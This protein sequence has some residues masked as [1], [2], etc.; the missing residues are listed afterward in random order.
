MAE[1]P[2]AAAYTAP[3]SAREWGS[4]TVNKLPVPGVLDARPL[5]TN[6]AKTECKPI[7]GRIV[8]TS[9]LSSCRR[10]LRAAITSQRREGCPESMYSASKSTDLRTSIKAAVAEA[11]PPDRRRKV[12]RFVKT[13]VERRKERCRLSKRLFRKERRQGSKVAPPFRTHRRTS[14]LV[15]MRIRLRRLN[16]NSRGCQARRTL[17]KAAQSCRLLGCWGKQVHSH[18]TVVRARRR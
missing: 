5:T 13:R 15:D 9:V 17:G 1:A 18:S 4:I 14:C 6:R 2:A 10:I 8:K 3:T 7:M 11:G 16:P 12:W